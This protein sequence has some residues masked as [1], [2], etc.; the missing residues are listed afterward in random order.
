MFP[1]LYR[2]VRWWGVLSWHLC[3]DGSNPGAGPVQHS[4]PGSQ[5]RSPCFHLQPIAMY[6]CL[7]MERTD[8]PK[9]PKQ[10]STERSACEGEGCEPVRWIRLDSFCPKNPLA[11]TYGMGHPKGGEK[12][13]TLRRPQ[14]DGD[15]VEAGASDAFLRVRRRSSSGRA[16]GRCPHPTRTRED[17]TVRP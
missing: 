7:C 13:P 10:S 11:G 4:P 17:Q 6:K 3:G 15:D 16:G 8:L 12:P 2:S 1:I 14:R 9:N 5:P